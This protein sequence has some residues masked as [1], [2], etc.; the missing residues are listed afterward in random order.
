MARFPYA[1]REPPAIFLIWTLAEA[2]QTSENTE[3]TR[4]ARGA[5]AREDRA[6]LFRSP[7]TI[8]GH[9]ERES[10]PQISRLERVR[11][12]ETSPLTSFYNSLSIALFLSSFRVVSFSRALLVFSCVCGWSWRSSHSQDLWFRLRFLRSRTI[13]HRNPLSLRVS[14]HHERNLSKRND[15][16]SLPTKQLD[17]RFHPCFFSPLSWRDDLFS[18]R[19]GI[20][21]HA[22]MY[23]YRLAAVSQPLAGFLR[24]A[25]RENNERKEREGRCR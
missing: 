9:E 22:H 20:Q 14:F 23:I 1:L 8:A 10:N 24:V 11:F 5:R 12:D 17:R 13:S 6:T 16:S 4:D 25:R 2:R 19:D 21:L 18:Q 7:Y 15:R 3:R